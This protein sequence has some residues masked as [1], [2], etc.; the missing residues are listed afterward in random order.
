MEDYTHLERK[1]SPITNK[2]NV[3][4]IPEWEK[5]PL[6]QSEDYDKQA[7]HLGKGIEK[8]KKLFSGNIIA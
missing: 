2:E 5:L 6:K 8:G 3:N 1:K 7:I 4:E